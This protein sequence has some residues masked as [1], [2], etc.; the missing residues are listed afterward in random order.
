MDLKYSKSTDTQHKIKLESKLLYAIWR[1]G[2]APVGLEV[3]LEVATSF[4]GNGATI[5]IK[6]KSEN[7]KKLGKLDGKVKNNIFVGALAIPD[8]VKIGDQ[9][10][11]EVD[12]PQ[13]GLSGESNRITAVS[14]VVV[15]NMKWSA[16]EARRGDT[17][18]LSADVQ[19]CKSGTDAMITI[20]EY[21]QDSVHDKIIDIPAVVTNAK[22]EVKWEYEYFEDT[23]E[24]PTQEEMQRYGK[25]YNPPE[26]FFIINIEGQKFG[27]KQE[28]GLLLF[29]DWIEVRLSDSLG[30][31]LADVQYTLYLPDGSQRKGRLS[32]DGSAREG[33]IPPGK[34]R[35]E[36]EGMKGRF[37]DI[38]M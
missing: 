2:T 7:G 32:A 9:V 15:T 36:F 18:T 16:K 19:G 29:R 24:V 38:S 17:L 30:Q 13:N 22:I 6:G 5:K 3:A 25:S 37:R 28:S 27:R 12:L 4:V 31:P 1:S 34:C 23:D 8:D 10:Y 11:F 14:S 21:D 35:F 26:Y 33:D 20:Y